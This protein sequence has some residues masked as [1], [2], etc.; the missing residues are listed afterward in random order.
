MKKIILLIATITLCINAY[1]KTIVV[2]TNIDFANAEQKIIANKDGKIY[3][4]NVIVDLSKIEGKLA[5]AKLI[6][7]CDV[8]GE[9]AINPSLTFAI[10][11]DEIGAVTLPLNSKQVGF[12]ITRDIKKVLSDGKKSTKI[13]V[14]SK[15]ANNKQRQV[16]IS[17]AILECSVEDEVYCQKQ[18]NTPIFEGGTMY[19]ESVFPLKNEGDKI[20]KINLYFKATKIIEAYT[21][22]GGKK[23]ILKQGK[24]Y[25]LKDGCIA[26]PDTTSVKIFNNDDIYAPATPEGIKKLGGSFFFPTIKKRALFREGTWFHKHMVYVSYKYS[27]K[28]DFVP[29][30]FDGKKLPKTLAKLRSGKPLC[31]VLYGDSISAGGN[32]S[33]R[34]NFPPYA[35]TWGEQFV[36]NLRDTYKSKITYYNRALGGT[37]SHWGAMCINDLVLPDNPDLLII[38]FGMNDRILAE[39]RK[40]YYQAMISA[41]LKKNPNAEF[42]L[43]CSIRGNTNW[44]K[45]DTHDSYEKSDKAM[46]CKNIAVADVRSAHTALL[47]KKRYIDM[48]GNHVNHPND[49]LIRTYVQA[50]SNILIP[51][52]K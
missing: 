11:G 24:D 36:E 12:D 43:V 26:F 28:S 39:K 23:R 4:A 10:D 30:K 15:G 18:W 49:F 13:R 45:F 19:A 52:K 41:V 29:E 42:I 35:K 6:F 46:Q 1:A 21:F 3:D 7:V 9:Q 14:F 8:L 2:P 25:I 38:A 47:T 50:L 37:R 31:V 27:E 17:K 22:L 51:Q 34:Y 20:A 33:A 40:K 44:Q 48:T 5:E 32:S 16:E